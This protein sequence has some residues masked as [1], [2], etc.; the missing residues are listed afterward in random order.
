[1]YFGHSLSLIHDAN[2]NRNLSRKSLPEKGWYNATY[3]NRWTYVFQK[4]GESW[5]DPNCGI[6]VH[7]FSHVCED[8]CPSVTIDN[9]CNA[10]EH[11][12]ICVLQK[13]GESW[14]YP[15][16]GT[17]VYLFSIVF[18]CWDLKAIII[19]CRQGNEYLLLSDVL[20]VH[21]QTQVQPHVPSWVLCGFVLWHWLVQCAERGEG[22]GLSVI[23]MTCPPIVILQQRNRIQCACLGWTTKPSC[24]G[25]HK[26]KLIRKERKY[27]IGL[28]AFVRL[29]VANESSQFAGTNK[30]IR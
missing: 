14:S 15:N 9:K 8:Y 13:E 26:V 25:C 24:C 19:A 18:C 16:C 7:L 10:W 21:W 12:C 3:E 11:R 29:D 2:W 22:G 30:Y 4:D 17:C 5:S 1:M 27:P 6:C 23:D 28:R 20:W